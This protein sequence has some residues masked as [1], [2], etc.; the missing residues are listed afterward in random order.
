MG[1]NSGF[2]GLRT[3]KTMLLKVLFSLFSSLEGTKL[4]LDITNLSESMSRCVCVSPLTLLKDSSPLFKIY[5]VL[6]VYLNGLPVNYLQSA[7]KN[8][9]CANS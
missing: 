2:K 5:Y 6:G 4:V 8:G 7:I 3:L 1:F 9:E